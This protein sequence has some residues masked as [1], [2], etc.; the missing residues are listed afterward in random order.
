MAAFGNLLLVCFL[1]AVSRA[2]VLNFLFLLFLLFLFLFLSIL[3]L[4]FTFAFIALFFCA[5]KVRVGLILTLAY[6]RSDLRKSS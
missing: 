1:L 3:I 4:I 5:S 6:E 2:I